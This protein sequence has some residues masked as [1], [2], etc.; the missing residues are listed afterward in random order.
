[1]NTTYITNLFSNKTWRKLFKH[2]RMKSKGLEYREVI[3]ASYAFNPVTDHIMT[4]SS[5]IFDL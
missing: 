5:N 4:A 2:I 1:M 3:A